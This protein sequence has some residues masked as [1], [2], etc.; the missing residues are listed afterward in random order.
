MMNVGIVK[1]HLLQTHFRMVGDLQGHRRHCSTPH[2]YCWF[3]LGCSRYLKHIPDVGGGG[4][5]WVVPQWIR[6][7]DGDVNEQKST[8]VSLRLASHE[9]CHSFVD[10]ELV[11]TIVGVCFEYVFCLGG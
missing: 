1:L 5:W 8:S 9:I 11:E 4:H 7:R 6:A 10:I 3:D 2:K